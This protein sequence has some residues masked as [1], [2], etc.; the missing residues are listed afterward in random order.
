MALTVPE[1]QGPLEEFLAAASDASGAM[2]EKAALLPGGSLQENWRLDVVFEGGREAGRQTL[3]LRANR[4][5]AVPAYLSRGQEFEVMKAV[6]GAGVTIPE[7]LWTSDGEGVLGRAFTVMRHVAGR[8][9]AHKIVRDETLGGPHDALAERIGEELAKIQSIRPESGALPFL[10]DPEAG[11]AA[12]QIAEMR[13]YLDGHADPHPAI[14]WGLRWAELNLPPAVSPVLRHGDFRTGNYLVDETGLTGIIDW[15]LASW[16]DPMEDLAW[17]CI[18]C[19]R[20]GRP[21]R[22]AGGLA[23]RAY[24]HRGY[25][26]VSGRRI[27]PVLDHYWAVMANLRWAVISM[28]QA[29]RHISG[30]DPSLQ[31]ALTGRMT[32]EMELEALRLIDEAG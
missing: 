15:E 23:A 21:D 6:H 29:E 14:E 22:D 27:D 16:G 25:E 19:W 2:I 31:L 1:A 30:R 28:Q 12:A 11:A 17:F 7:P 10:R 20:W 9:E 13:T 18:K 4:P 8:A 24:F 32:A 5:D 26:R 3:V